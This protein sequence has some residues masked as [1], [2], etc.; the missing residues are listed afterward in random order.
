MQ[1]GC[2][3]AGF[4]IVYTILSEPE[5]DLLQSSF[6]RESVPSGLPLIAVLSGSSLDQPPTQLL[7]CSDV[8]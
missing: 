7:L 8:H 4:L 1:V 5:V 6:H 3:E 2:L